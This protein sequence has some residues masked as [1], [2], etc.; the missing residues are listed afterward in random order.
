MTTFNA[1]Y[2]VL[3]SDSI[4]NFYKSFYLK[5]DEILIQG[6][7]SGSQNPA[8]FLM[9]M[10][11]SFMI[12]ING[13]IK[14]IEFIALKAE[15]NL[16]IYGNVQSFK[17]TCTYNLFSEKLFFNFAD[18]NLQMNSFNKRLLGWSKSKNQTLNNW[19][20][21]FED[22]FTSNYTIILMSDKKIVLNGAGSVMGARIGVFGEDLT[23]EFGTKISTTAY[24]CSA[25]SGPGKGQSIL[26]EENYCGGM[27]GSYGGYKGYGLG[28]LGN[29]SKKESY[30][31]QSYARQIDS[32]EQNLPYGGLED[33]NYEGSGG[34]S[35]QDNS[36]EKMSNKGGSGGGI[37]IFGI[38]N[39]L[40]NHGLIESNGE[41]TD[42]SCTNNTGPG[43]GSGGSIQM[44]LKFL[45]GTGNI[46]ANG[47]NSGFYCGEGGGGRIKVY[48][49]SWSDESLKSNFTQFWFGNIQ[50]E[51]GRRIGYDSKYKL[52]ILDFKGSFGS[53]RL[54]IK[55]N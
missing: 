31:C 1:K 26:H 50:V 24:G 18:K 55:K 17:Q 27:G 5:A 53:K 10:S 2:F 42:Q 47:G 13:V 51:A 45:A 22:L 8:T 7:I 48:F 15:E 19:F 30:L 9:I 54:T 35:G 40:T 14:D 49:L 33:P 39:N 37:I 28:V 4:I 34:G 36:K 44:N 52:S 16:V 20:L 41:S 23:L 32:K 25:D 43:A 21:L 38:Y 46:T 12:D 6:T 11:K 29:D 3:S